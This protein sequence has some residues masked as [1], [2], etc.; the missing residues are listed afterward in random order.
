MDILCRKTNQN[1]TMPRLVANAKRAVMILGRECDILPEPQRRLEG[2]CRFSIR[3]FYFR[4]NQGG[5]IPAKDIQ[6]DCKISFQW[7]HITVL[8]DQP[9]VGLFLKMFISL[10]RKG[11]IILLPDHVPLGLVSEKIKI[12]I[13]PYPH[14]RFPAEISLLNMP[15]GI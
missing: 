14:D 9:S 10:S 2:F 11:E 5:Q 13:P 12:I 3:K 1:A 7:N 6:F 4:Q 8:Y 15:A